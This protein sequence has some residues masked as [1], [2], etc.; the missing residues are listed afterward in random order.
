MEK[1]GDGRGSH[2]PAKGTGTLRLLS[3]L[4]SKGWLERWGLV[5]KGTRHFSKGGKEVWG[6]GFQAKPTGALR[7]RESTGSSQAP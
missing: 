6:L 5:P 3:E 2:L 1:G 4:G 7:F